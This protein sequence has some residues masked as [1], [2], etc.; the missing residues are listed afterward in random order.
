[1]YVPR[2]SL[3]AA[4]WASR[5]SGGGSEVQP[6]TPCAV[7][8]TEEFVSIPAIFLRRDWEYLGT[9]RVLTVL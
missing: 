3:I 2:G 7:L 8:C 9:D 5:G 4:V 1:M 6:G